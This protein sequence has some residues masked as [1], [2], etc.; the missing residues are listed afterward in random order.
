MVLA[1]EVKLP[2]D[3]IHVSALV[4]DNLVWVHRH[5]GLHAK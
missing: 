1:D 3:C 2:E 5:L 4:V